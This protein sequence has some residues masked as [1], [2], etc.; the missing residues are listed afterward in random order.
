MAFA[1]E[2]P[3]HV[4][5]P[6]T[7]IFVKKSQKYQNKFKNYVKMPRFPRGFNKPL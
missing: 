3:K 2:A 1:G 5:R 6:K 4:F 7:L